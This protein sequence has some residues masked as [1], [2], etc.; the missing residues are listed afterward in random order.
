[1]FEARRCY[2][3]IVAVQCI[4]NT[5][6]M[7]G[8]SYIAG[9]VKNYALTVELKMNMSKKINCCDDVIRHDAIRVLFFLFSIIFFYYIYSDNTPFTIVKDTDAGTRTATLRYRA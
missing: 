5:Q 2:K 7:L 1:M 4:E 9:E 3:K 8:Y 6:K